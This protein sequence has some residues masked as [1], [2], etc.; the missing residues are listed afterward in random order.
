MERLRSGVIIPMYNGYLN[1]IEEMCQRSFTL[2]SESSIQGGQKE[3][4]TFA[5]MKR[6]TL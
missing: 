6:N 2:G 1:A 4:R 5:R 3:R